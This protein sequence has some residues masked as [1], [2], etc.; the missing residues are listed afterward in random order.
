MTKITDKVTV[1]LYGD[2]SLQNQIIQL[3]QSSGLS[4]KLREGK[5]YT[6]KRGEEG[7]YVGALVTKEPK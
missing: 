4:V 7:H 5:D 2:E 1:Q 3:L 6:T